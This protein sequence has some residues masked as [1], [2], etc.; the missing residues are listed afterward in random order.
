MPTVA[1]V[2]S[3]LIQFFYNDHDPPHFHARGRAFSAR[4]RIADATVM[5]IRGLMPTSVRADI[6]SWAG[7]HRAAL[8]ENWQLARANQPLKRIG[9]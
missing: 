5:D 4:V 6:L 7:Q 9:P 2:R 3:V 8:A 1:I